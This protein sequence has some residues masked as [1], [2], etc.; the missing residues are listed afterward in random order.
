MKICTF[1]AIDDREEYKL[2]ICKEDFSQ[3]NILYFGVVVDVVVTSING[4][5][6]NDSDPQQMVFEPGVWLK[7]FI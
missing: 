6:E 3:G 1:R 4:D 2:V 7:Q 5:S